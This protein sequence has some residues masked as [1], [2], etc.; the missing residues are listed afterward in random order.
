MKS[1]ILFVVFKTFLLAWTGCAVAEAVP[2]TPPEGKVLVIIGQ[3]KGSI[4]DYVRGTGIVPGGTMV[5]TSVQ[6]AEGLEAA[7]DHGG[8]VQHGQY[9]LDQ[10][11]H[12]V[13]QVG[14]WMVD[15]LQGVVD[16]KYDN[17]IDKLGAWIMRARRPVF[18]RIGYEFDMPLN[19]YEPLAYIKAFRYIVDR[20]RKEQVNNV[21]YVWHSYANLPQHPWEDWYP[22]DGYVDWFAVSVF[23]RPN[24]Y[25][26]KFAEMA[27][28]HR[29]GFMIAESTPKGVG[30]SHGEAT[31]QYWYAPFFRFIE[32]EKV[33]VVSYINYNWETKPQFAG[34]GWGDARIESNEMV[35][36]RW[37][38]EM[39]QDKYLFK[40]AGGLR[41]W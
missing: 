4:D 37:K 1:L 33:Q 12:G 26:K 25:M 10:Y 24:I 40:V 13:L 3:D 36:R 2:F 39:A 29:K 20:L 11:P 35:K 14:L 18:L 41:W 34:Q 32:D 22:G 30:V 9:L 19:K 7:A 5:Y 15:G 21:A 28:T 38:E 6:E 17:N 16:G 23:G 31:W 8:G 27:R